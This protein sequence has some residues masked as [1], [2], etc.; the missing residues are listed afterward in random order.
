MAPDRAIAERRMEERKKEKTRLTYLACANGDGTEKIPLLF[1]GKARM[2]RVFAKN[3]GQQ[4]GLDYHSNTKAWMITIMFYDWLWRFSFYITRTG[5]DRKLFC[6]LDNFSANGS[7]ESIPVLDNV[8]VMF[9]SP[10]TTSRLQPMDASTIAAV[11]PPY[12]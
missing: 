6:L 12:R 4:L 5:A 3:T 7:E 11:T 2:S 8:E 9:L 10:N 1:I